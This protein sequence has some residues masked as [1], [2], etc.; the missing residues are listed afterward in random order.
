[1]KTPAAPSSISSDQATATGPDPDRFLRAAYRRARL[2]PLLWSLAL[3]LLAVLGERGE[4]AGWWRL[5]SVGAFVA[6]CL[7][8]AILIRWLR[9]ERDLTMRAM[10]RRLDERWRLQARVETA[11]ELA[12][13]STALARRQRADTAR[14]LAKR[15]LPWAW[16]WSA[17]WTLLAAVL[18]LHTE[19]DALFAPAAPP[20]EERN[21]AKLAPAAEPSASS[22]APASEQT[23]AESP[24]ARPETAPTPA[25]APEDVGATISWLTPAA[26]INATAVEDVPLAAEV[27]TRSGFARIALEVTVNGQPRPAVALPPE[28]VARLAAPMEGRIEMSLH[29]DELALNEYDLVGY[30]LR[31]EPVAH[32]A[33]PPVVSSLQF[34]AIK[35]IRAPDKSG[36]GRGGQHPEIVLLISQQLELLRENFDLVNALSLPET[37]GSEPRA[38]PAVRQGELADAAAKL[39]AAVKRRGAPPAIATALAQVEQPMRRAAT[40]LAAGD[41]AAALESQQ[42]A[43]ALLAAT[44]RNLRQSN[45]TTEVGVVDDNQ[46]MNVF[47]SPAGSA[48][49][50]R[51][52]TVAGRLEELAR[53]QSEITRQLG[54]LAAKADGV[55]PEAAATAAL[56]E[57]EGLVAH[58]TSELAEQRGLAE[59]ARPPTQVAAREATAAVA[60]LSQNDLH[61]ALTRA[62]EAAQNLQE[63]VRRQELAGRAA[64]VAAL[65]QARRELN[66]LAREPS[67][68]ERD[69]ALRALADDLAGDARE[70]QESGS[71][72]AATEIAAASEGIRSTIGRAVE[73][74]P[75]AQRRAAQAEASLVPAREGMERAMR[76]LQRGVRKLREEQGDGRAT[77]ESP[78]RDDIELASQMA[79]AIESQQPAAGTPMQTL[80]GQIARVLGRSRDVREVRVEL[81]AAAATLQDLLGSAPAGDERKERIRLFNPE[82]VDPEY[83]PAVEGYFDR[84]SREDARR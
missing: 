21:E 35:P 31:A 76:Q 3:M 50:P 13:K 84:L 2:S 1:M 37:N 24:V 60:R 10:A 40:Q 46:P 16:L 34:I 20:A 81:L 55:P 33:T 7:A 32:Q 5:G 19:F 23:P 52:A 42:E 18:L 51:T 36:K 72:V 73:A 80:A 71:E 68:A 59:E 57:K 48:L 69:Q 11:W 75:D 78:G 22:V 39:A 8:A 67:G 9:D 14:R 43:L 29:L 28:T 83:L 27:T 38:T 44:Q 30:F 64:A 26:E 58:E 4:A 66:R 61:R 47:Q 53:R 41:N 74:M 56:V 62:A 45:R 82:E 15:R 6:S 25:S 79:A 63:A 70:Q 12:G 77:D 49:P 65:E 54:E 17:G